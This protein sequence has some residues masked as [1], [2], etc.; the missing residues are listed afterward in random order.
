MVGCLEEELANKTL[1][2][3]REND[4]STMRDKE[5][6]L[7]ERRGELDRENSELYDRVAALEAEKTQLLV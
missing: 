6:Q 2:A 7:E 4:Q 3:E 1:R 5:D